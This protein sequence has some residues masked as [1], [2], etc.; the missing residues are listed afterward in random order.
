MEL[1]KEWRSFGGSL[2]RYRHTSAALGGLPAVFAVYLPPAALV[3]GAPPVPVLVWLSGL[4]CT[5]ENVHAKSGIQ[6]AAAAHGIAVVMPDTS[7]RGAGL[8]PE[9]TASWDFGAG[10]GFYVNAT[11]EP[12]ARHYR[13]YEYVTSELPGV[14]AAG[15]PS[16]DTARMGISG[17]SMGGMGAL[18]M[19]LKNPARFRSVSAFAPIAH[20]SECPWGVKAF[21]GYLG[22][23]RAAWAAYDPTELVKGYA[24]P[25]LHILVDQGASDDFLAAGQLRP[26]DFLDAAAAAGVS[27]DYRERAG[28][29]HSYYYIATFIDEHVAHHARFL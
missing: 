3:E 6:R 26:R 25:D 18:Q 28:Y 27:V 13:M 14:L 22:P 29:D 2:R 12:W 19:A 23:D 16:V 20:P 15:L 7:P 8:G 9:E 1:I 10:A 21:T 24:G 4:T 11:Q 17:H 5:D